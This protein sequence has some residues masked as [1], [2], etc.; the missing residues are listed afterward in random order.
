MEKIEAIAERIR[1][2]F[3]AHTSARDRALSQTRTLV[4]HCA[5]AIRAVHRDESDLGENVVGHA[6]ER[7]RQSCRI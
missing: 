5:H 2:S 6:A 4:R 1:A 7:N 3:D